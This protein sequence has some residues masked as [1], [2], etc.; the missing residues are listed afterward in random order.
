MKN[1]GILG[2][3]MDL[4]A[5]TRGASIGPVAIRK[6]GLHQELIRLGLAFEDF[7]DLTFAFTEKTSHDQPNLKYKQEVLQVSM[8]LLETVDDI[9]Q[10]GYFPLVLGGDHSVAIGSIAGITRNKKNL[11]I[12]WYDAH[13]DM[14]TDRTTPSGNIHGMP[15]AVNIGLGDKELVN[16]DGRNGKVKPEHIVI[17]GA[18][19]LDEPEKDLIRSTGVTVFTMEHI[20]R[21]GIEK[22]IERAI[23]IASNGTDGIH[24][25]LDLDALDPT[26][27][28]GVG[29]AVPGGITFRESRYAM[30]LLSASGYITSMDVVEVNPLLDVQNRTAEVAV[31]LVASIFGKKLL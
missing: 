7:G 5:G 31:Q 23:A 30:E 9:Q 20:D 2:V 22:V 11:G 17:I 14:N 28:P 21:M 13:G 16:L 1:V 27:A 18:R 12:I 29:T 15:L 6:A 3:A 19:D 10:K 24:L 25:S 8:K 4:A 26:V